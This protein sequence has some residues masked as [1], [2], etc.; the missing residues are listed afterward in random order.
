MNTKARTIHPILITGAS[1]GIGFALADLL[2]HQETNHLII[3]GRNPEKLQAA[4]IRLEAISTHTLV[5][6]LICDQSKKD[7]L[8]NL[9]ST[10]E[11][12]NSW[13]QTAILNIGINFFHEYGAR[14]LH[15]LTFEQIHQ[16]INVNVT[17]TIYLLSNILKHMRARK[18]GRII[19]IGSQGW[20][21]GLPG[22]SLYNASKSSLVGLKNSVANEYQHNG[23][24]CHLIHPGVVNNPRTESLR[25]KHPELAASAISEY[26]VAEAIYG[27]LSID[28]AADNGQEIV[29]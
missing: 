13:P 7:D 18:N 2:I 22:Q 3:T 20:L 19:L 25:C 4:K 10:F 21:H 29:I 8:D 15:N 17:H 23:I 12:D 24:F 26:Q 6:T 16:S 11:N 27:L 9:F 14:K 5:D 1:S 28:K